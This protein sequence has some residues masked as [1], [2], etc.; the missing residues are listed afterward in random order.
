MKRLFTPQWID[1]EPVVIPAELRAAL[2]GSELFL[3]TLARR[4]LTDPEQ[5]RAFLDPDLYTPASAYE[6]PD[7]ALAVTRLR[8]ALSLHERIGIWGDF[9]VDGQTS[10]TVLVSTFRFL[11]ADV[12]YH[13]PLRKTESHGIKLEY[14]Q[15]FLSQGIQLLI[16]CDTGIS[17]LDEIAYA[18][19]QGVD[20][21]LTDHHS[22]PPQL[23]PALAVINPQ[24][25][26][27]E[28]PLH[29]LS[30]VGAAYELVAALCAELGKSEF[31]PSLLDLVALGLIADM[32]TL[33]ADTRYLT[34]LGLQKLQSDP[35][36]ALAKILKE[37]NVSSTEL[38]E[39]TVSFIIAPRM[40]AVGRLSDANPMVEF[41]LESDPVKLA[42]RYAQIEGLNAQRKLECDL[43]YQGAQA[44]IEQSPQILEQPILILAHSE[45]EGGVVGIVASRL[46]EQYHRPAILLS[47][48]DEEIMSGSCRSIE[49]IN[50]TQAIRENSRLLLGFGGHPMAAGLLLK[51]EH[52]IEFQHA[53]YKTIQRM[54]VDNA[55]SPA[56]PIDAYIEPEKLDLTA[57][58]EI[59]RLAP[60]GPGNSPL[61]FA[62]KE[63]EISDTRLFGKTKEH[64]EVLLH[65]SSGQDT[66]F[67]W[68]QGAGRSQPEGKF[69]LLYQARIS[70]Y[71]SQTK[72]IFEW[73]E[74]RETADA[75]THRKFKPGQIQ[76]VDHRSVELSPE[77]IQALM[78]E[79][80]C[81][82]WAEG[83]IDTP[84]TA[85]NRNQ[86]HPAQTLLLWGLPPSLQTLTQAIQ[87]TV[88]H[89]IYWFNHMPA[90][91]SLKVLIEKTA[92]LTKKSLAQS[93]PAQIDVSALTAELATTPALA[94]LILQW[95]EAS[96]Y[97]QIIGTTETGF[98]LISTPSAPDPLKAAHLQARIKTLYTETIE[99]RKYLQETDSLELLTGN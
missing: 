52:F 13:I 98:R 37:N 1:P 96:G 65:T 7:M 55:V 24:R 16:T 33:T 22:L 18:Q 42:T 5:A 99:F 74:F 62:V 67:T 28:H 59:A 82:C 41:L 75:Q 60:F 34:Q 90:E 87:T 63:A 66:R 83:T 76:N 93:S 61:R 69:D 71:S 77:E 51:L 44:Q 70:T 84:F 4:G 12:V 29:S 53:M 27:E 43:V 15:E 9:D 48:K 92:I 19:A 50:I 85:L 78:Q 36:P 40:N 46:V 47:I 32:A 17:A 54:V 11:G 97:V 26:P 21:I 64:L 80:D 39:E 86:L 30:G 72:V 91:N 56:Y 94:R 58:Q 45:W 20:V 23:P 25:L 2:S 81:L 88:P 14:L 49:G 31:P 10:T 8:Q 6:L 79:P 95:L 57:I 35:R 73:E 38:T 68:W 89:T 3:Q